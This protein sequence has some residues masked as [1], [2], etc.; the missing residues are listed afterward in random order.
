VGWV[1]LERRTIHFP[2]LLADPE[3]HWPEAQASARREDLVA[4]VRV[5]SS[6]DLL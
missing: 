3:Y 4:V 1:V 6:D 5:E 2:D